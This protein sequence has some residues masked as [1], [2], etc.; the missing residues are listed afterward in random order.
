MPIRKNPKEH[1]MPQ[2]NPFVRRAVFVTAALSVAIASVAFLCSFGALA[3]PAA[4][5]NDA[6]K[7]QEGLL[8]A[9]QRAVDLASEMYNKGVINAEEVER[10]RRLLVETELR[11]AGTAEQRRRILAS[12]I[13]S[14]KA[15]EQSVDLRVKAGLATEL[16]RTE[17]TAD[18]LDLELRLAE[19]R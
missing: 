9:R 10:S 11:V 15:W 6:A 1:E 13:D 16:T 19:E 8:A 3:E 4:P 2:F 17:A 12:A 5:V 18:R 7:L 14:A